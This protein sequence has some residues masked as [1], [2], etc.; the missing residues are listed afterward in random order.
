MSTYV[1]EKKGF[2]FDTNC[3]T[4]CRFALLADKKRMYERRNNNEQA[5]EL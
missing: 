3:E 1:S 4:A 2:N 5:T